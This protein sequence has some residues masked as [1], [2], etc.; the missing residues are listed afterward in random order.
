MTL[1]KALPREIIES[2]LCRRRQS[3]LWTVGA[4]SRFSFGIQ[5]P[6][7]FHHEAPVPVGL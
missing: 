1:A 2:I 3:D 6:R 5:E 4:Y 7:Q